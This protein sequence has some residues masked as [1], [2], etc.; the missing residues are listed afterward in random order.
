M[1]D[2]ESSNNLIQRYQAVHSE[3]DALAQQQKREVTL[4]AV[5]KKHCAENIEAVYHQG[6]NCFAENYVQEGVDKVNGLAHLNI[7]WHFIG[8]IQSNKTRLVAEHFSW[9]HTI[10]RDKIAQRLNDQRPDHLTPLNVLIQ[11]NISDQDSKSGVSLD[12]V[13]ALAHCISQLPKLCLRGLMC[14]PAPQ[15]EIQLKNEFAA[16]HNAYKTL[17]TQYTNVDT[18]SMGMSGD[19][20]L[21]ITCGSNMVRIGTAIFGQRN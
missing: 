11:V 16:M 7:D 13:E 14:I 12:D 3:V 9:V 8:P 19:L 15:D 2:L 18:L 5:S 20:K 17:Q 21:A 1:T 6:Q 10:D 4:L